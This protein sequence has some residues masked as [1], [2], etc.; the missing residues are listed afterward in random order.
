MKFLT[1][2]NHQLSSMASSID[3]KKNAFVTGLPV[4]DA[5]VPGGFANGVMHEILVPPRAGKPKYFAMLLARSAM[6]LTP[7]PGMPEEGWGEDSFSIGKTALQMPKNSHP[8]LS[9]CTG[10]G[11]K[12]SGRIAWCDPRGELWPAAL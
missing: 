9:R 3:G 8:A 10:R 1:L 6:F 4:L 7:S 5:L 2:S 11:E 12:A